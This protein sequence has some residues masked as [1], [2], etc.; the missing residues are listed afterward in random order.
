M[1]AKSNYIIPYEYLIKVPFGEGGGMSS[2]MNV[3]SSMV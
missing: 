2:L 3:E 1:L